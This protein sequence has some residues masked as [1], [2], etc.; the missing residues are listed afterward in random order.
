MQAGI[1]DH[2]SGATLA[3]LVRRGIIETRTASVD[4]ATGPGRQRQVRLT[5]AG[6][7]IAREIQPRNAALNGLPA[8]LEDALS[9]VR[10][11]SPPGLPKTAISRSAARSLGPGGYHYIDDANAWAYELTSKGAHYLNGLAGSPGSLVPLTT[12]H[13]P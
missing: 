7:K 13:P 4:T 8:W 1:H 10:D 9:A 12:G 3:A 5:R 11:A 6:R 2:G